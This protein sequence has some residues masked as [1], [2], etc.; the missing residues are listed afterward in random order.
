MCSGTYK[1][2]ASGNTVEEFPST[3]DSSDHVIPSTESQEEQAVEQN[4]NNDSV[5]TG[6]NA[7]A[8]TGAETENVQNGTSTD[9]YYGDQEL[10]S[11]ENNT[12]TEEHIV[13]E[14]APSSV[15]GVTGNND[16]DVIP[17]LGV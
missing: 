3:D 8:T 10:P 15:P 17:A 5:Y 2:T 11:V 4:H 13:S 14:A 6:E 9:A 12:K 7:P 1:E 16:A